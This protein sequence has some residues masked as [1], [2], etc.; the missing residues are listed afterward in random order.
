MSDEAGADDG[1]VR[2]EI[3]QDQLRALKRLGADAE[4]VALPT[5]SE[6][7]SRPSTQTRLPRRGQ[8]WARA[9]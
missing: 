2:S 6:C 7:P 1:D 9:A 4:A 5:A 8:L 3:D